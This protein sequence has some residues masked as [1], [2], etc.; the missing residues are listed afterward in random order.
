M[1]PLGMSH[2]IAFAHALGG[3]KVSFDD[4]RY[5]LNA[6]LENLTASLGGDRKRARRIFCESMPAEHR[7]IFQ[8][9]LSKPKPGR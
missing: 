6:M 3:E 9:L 5:V 7:G 8:A 4:L 2:L 1:P